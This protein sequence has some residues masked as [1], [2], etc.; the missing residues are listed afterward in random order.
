MITVYL[1]LVEANKHVYIKY[2]LVMGGG[3]GS[4]ASVEK[5]EYIQ[6]FGNV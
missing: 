4:R 6:S 5:F 2:R 1:R 3:G